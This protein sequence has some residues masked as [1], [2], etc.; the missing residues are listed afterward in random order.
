MASAE[1][2]HA[3]IADRLDVMGMGPRRA[4][5][6]SPLVG[7]RDRTSDQRSASASATIAMSRCALIASS[8]PER[9]LLIET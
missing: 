9:A 4:V 5:D 2:P 8:R 1:Q 6:G 3:A 7:F